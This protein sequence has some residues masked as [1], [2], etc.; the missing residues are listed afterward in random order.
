MH[1]ADVVVVERLRLSA[2]LKCTSIQASR[3]GRRRS[4]K[5]TTTTTSL[6]RQ[7]PRTITPVR[8]RCS[9][10]DVKQ[11]FTNMV[12]SKGKRPHSQLVAMTIPYSTSA[13]PTI[14]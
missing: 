1:A 10:R 8:S 14:S 13:S 7:Q 2:T 11:C 12:D 4:K 5:V 6:L 3:D 9:E